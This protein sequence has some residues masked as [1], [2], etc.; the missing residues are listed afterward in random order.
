MKLLSFFL[1]QNSFGENKV[2]HVSKSNHFLL[3]IHFQELS[4]D[5][6]PQ[7]ILVLVHFCERV[8]PSS[9]HVVAE[10]SYIYLNQN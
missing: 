4:D 7:L 1:T 2:V 9:D 5:H 3:H 6:F 8:D 10:V